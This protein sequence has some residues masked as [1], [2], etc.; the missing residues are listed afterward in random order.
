MVKIFI[1]G[2]EGTTGLKIYERF[3]NR[4]DIEILTIDEEFR[5]I[6]EERAKMI[7]AS[8]FTFLCLPDTAAIESAKLCTNPKTVI[9]DASTAHRTNPDWA[10]GFPEL[11]PAFR[12][13]IMKSNRIAVPGCYASGSIAILY[14]LIK[15]GI[16][17]KDYPV[18]IHAVSG[19]SGAGKK[20]IALY[21]SQNRNPELDSPRLYA[22][23]Q[24]HKHLPEI[25]KISGLEFEPI[26]N[27]YV[28]DYYQGMTVSI[29]FHTRL[30]NKN[31]KALE[32][33]EMFKN[34][35]KN[36][37]FIKVAD[38]LNGEDFLQ[39]QFIPANTLAG[40]NNMQI[41][42]CGNDERIVVTSRFDN[43]GKGASGAAVQCL[44]IRMG[45]DETEGL[46]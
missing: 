7:N 6:P 5:K 1:D 18:V 46:K 28:C 12:E 23:S 14:P 13:K 42:V 19:Y 36:T 16:L 15:S 44:N 2:K 21:E 45:I 34:H 32:V 37:N 3:S 33:L 35:Y 27:P 9:I 24:H 43:L 20:A 39:E 22:L 11:E 8:D 17:P 38:K 29:G 25:Q 26:F 4:K 30:L 31:V 40:T 41:F 10:Y